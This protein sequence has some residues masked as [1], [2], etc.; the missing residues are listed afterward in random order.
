MLTD[1]GTGETGLIVVS[2]GGRE[3]YRGAIKDSLFTSSSSSLFGSSNNEVYIGFTAA[4]S[5]GKAADLDIRS[6]KI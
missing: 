3:L 4:S 1:T 2:E 6:L 5:T